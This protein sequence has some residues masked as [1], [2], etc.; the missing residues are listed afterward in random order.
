PLDAH[1]VH[2]VLLGQPLNL[3]QHLDL[4]QGVPAP[5]P[6]GPARRDESQ[7][8]VLSQG[9]R[10]HTS[11]LRSHGDDVQRF[12]VADQPSGSGH[13][14]DESAFG[15]H[16]H[17]S[18]A[19]AFISSART[20]SPDVAARYSSSAFRAS[21]LRF[22]GTATSTVTS[23]SP[24]VPSLRAAPLPRTRNVRPL[25]VPGGSRSVTGAPVNVGTLISPPNAASGKVTGTV[26]VRCSPRRPK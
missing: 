20:S 1:E 25:G 5:A 17:L 23:R 13:S 16:G 15:V 4:A 21:L 22:C 7:P 11:H 12:V 10:M 6:H 2:T 8:V 9:L 3:A 14:D 26:T 24:R 18:F 19:T